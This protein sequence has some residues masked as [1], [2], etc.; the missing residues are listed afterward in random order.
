MHYVA[1][2]LGCA[3]AEQQGHGRNR[4]TAAA[5]RVCQIQPNMSENIRYILVFMWILKRSLHFRTEKSGISECKTN[6]QA[7]KRLDFVR[8]YRRQIWYQSQ[9][10]SILTF[11]YKFGTHTRYDDTCSA[12][13]TIMMRC[14]QFI[15]IFCLSTLTSSTFCGAHLLR[16]GYNLCATRGVS[17]RASRRGASLD[18]PLPARP[19]SGVQRK[20][21][22]A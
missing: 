16:G 1:L 22:S 7:Q 12:H 15:F 2:Q 10:K 8:N 17:T 13:D 20:R 9:Y 19:P 6:A 5:Q 4:H 11:P 21:R 18:I 14:F 3:P